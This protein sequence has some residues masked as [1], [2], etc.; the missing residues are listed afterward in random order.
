MNISN[1]LKLFLFT[2]IIY[3]ALSIVLDNE[4]TAIAFCFA[5][6]E[7][8]VFALT[9]T[10]IESLIVRSIIN[11][12]KIVLLEN[13]SVI[14][15]SSASYLKSKSFAVGG[16]IILTNIRISFKSHSLNISAAEFSITYDQI[17]DITTFSSLFIKNG[18]QLALTDGSTIKLI[19]NDSEKFQHLLLKEVTGFQQSK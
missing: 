5:V 12:T 16:K 6:A 9:I 19:I 18:I 10:F 3:L 13:E 2:F 1:K 14:I 4:Y 8:L 15:E 17:N 11:N 7:S